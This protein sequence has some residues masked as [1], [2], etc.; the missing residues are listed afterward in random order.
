M[1]LTLY[2]GGKAVGEQSL[3]IGQKWEW[4]PKARK[5]ADNRLDPLEERTEAVHF[6]AVPPGTLTLEVR[7]VNARM[8][9]KTARYHHLR[10]YP[11][12]V[13]VEQFRRSL[14]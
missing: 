10:N 1:D 5:L 14:K 13:V 2:A 4:W 7:V 8:T 6:P 9:K 12:E 11:I 3:R